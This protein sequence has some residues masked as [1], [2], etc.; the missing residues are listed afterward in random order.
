MLRVRTATVVKLD[1]TI[2]NV[3]TDVAVKSAP[4]WVSPVSALPPH[5]PIR[6]YEFSHSNNLMMMFNQ[7]LVMS[8]LILQKE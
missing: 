5:G 4:A 2:C 1:F 3:T 6:M 7:I 8:L